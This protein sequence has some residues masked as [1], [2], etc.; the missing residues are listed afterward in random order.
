MSAPAAEPSPLLEAA[1]RYVACGLQVFPCWELRPDGTDC[2]CPRG[3]P[4]R[5]AAGHCGSPGKHPR[6]PA[7]VK[8][9][10]T[11]A[12]TIAR[13]W[14]TWPR[15]HVAIA[16]GAS[17]LLVVD[18]DP[19]NG[20]D[21]SLAELEAAHGP[22]PPTPRQL[23]GGGGVHVLFRRPDRK[24]VRGPRHGLGRGVDVKADGG[25]II[26]APS[27]HLSGRGYVWE[28][29]SSLDDLPIADPPAWLLERLD[30]RSLR[31]ATPATTAVT[32]GL[33]GAALEAAGWLG[34]PL[35]LDKSAARCPQ[36]DQHTTG[37]RFNGSTVAYAPQKPGGLG[38]FHC[39][40]GHCGELTPDDVLEALP[41]ATVTA[42]RAALRARGIA[43]D[44]RPRDDVP[45]P[46]DGDVPPHATAVPKPAPE[47]PAGK[48][49][50]MGP[51]DL[52]VALTTD[53]AWAGCLEHDTFADRVV[54]RRPV[55]RLPGL[56]RPL[57]GA[58]LADRDLTYIAHWA[59]MKRRWSLGLDGVHAACVA[60][61]HVTPTHPVRAYLEGLVWDRVPR[62][63]LWL[64]TYLHAPDAPTTTA[65]GTWTL[66]AAVARIYQP[67]CKADHVLI[68]EGPQAAGK[69]EAI[70]VLGGPWYH[71]QLPN[72]LGER[73]GQ[74]LQGRWLIEIGELD[75]FH[76][77]AVSRVKDFVSRPVD[78]YRPSYGRCSVTRPRQCIFIGTT[79][80]DT[81]LRDPTGGRRFW[82]VATGAIRLEALRADRDQLW[83][84]AVVEYRQG[85]TWWPERDWWP[86][87]QA[88]QEARYEGDPW[89]AV[90]AD[91][92]AG[93]PSVTTRE[94]LEGP[95]HKL[96]EHWTRTDQMRVADVLKRLGWH[97]RGDHR[98][99]RWYPAS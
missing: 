13:W 77:I 18:V 9:A 85:T 45:P 66:I 57:V 89:E 46:G 65:I 96:I 53:P 56:P 33:L 26:A 3:H 60:A 25:Y 8:D 75:A 7:G 22:L 73:P 82:P 43:A 15:A 76:G 49:V 83:A 6:T 87:L 47:P 12:A 32:D 44:E 21:D 41:A 91:H 37:S 24:H 11:D 71:P 54:W 90:I 81:Y 51:G 68:L 30:T 19:R 80:E 86:Q 95:L 5:D 67:G 61:A 74:E 10:T 4:S 16:A 84:E 59:A 63:A 79:N 92:I 27:G 17:N 42:A 78:I 23:T 35:G 97:R 93:L 34:R 88:I 48:R 38:W 64:Q 14:S 99:R 98:V 72:L 62:L 20:G 55:P 58:E 40:H 29:G 50:R 94:I 36:E 70:R 28:I 39:S 31:D 2:A 1:R 52:A 69:S